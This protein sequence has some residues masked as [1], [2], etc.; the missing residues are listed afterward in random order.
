[1]RGQ[2]NI[3]Y[4]ESLDISRWTLVKEDMLERP[5][6]QSVPFMHNAPHPDSYRT[7]IARIYNPDRADLQSVP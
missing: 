6:P 3:V 5:A 4:F 1:V 7:Q 2:Y